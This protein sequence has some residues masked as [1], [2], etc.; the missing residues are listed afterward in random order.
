MEAVLQLQ[1][2]PCL[3]ES[4]I[5]K[6]VY[7]L[8]LPEGDSLDISSPQQAQELPSQEAQKLPWWRWLSRRWL[9]FEYLKGETLEPGELWVRSRLIPVSSEALAYLLRVRIGACRHV[10][11]RHVIWHRR[12]CCKKKTAGITWMRDIYVFPAGSSNN[13]NATIETTGLVETSDRT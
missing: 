11:A 5:Q 13:V 9:A 10:G 1:R 12:R 7:S 3:E 4:G 2:A 8:S 6:G